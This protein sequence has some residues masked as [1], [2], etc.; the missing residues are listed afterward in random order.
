MESSAVGNAD[1]VESQYLQSNGQPS[2]P[3]DENS[4]LAGISTPP[5]CS[6]NGIT[7]GETPIKGSKT[8]AAADV[9]RGGVAKDATQ[10]NEDSQTWPHNVASS[11]VDRS[12]PLLVPEKH[13]QIKVEPI[14]L[15][16][17]RFRRSPSPGG[18]DRVKVSDSQADA[19]TGSIF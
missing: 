7:I 6:A 3:G 19:A 16:D 13:G 1:A 2:L 8:K 11:D 4:L 12:L 17:P 9:T 14:G 15:T 5:S 10:G 18:T